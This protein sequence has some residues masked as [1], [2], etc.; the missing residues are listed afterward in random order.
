MGRIQK[1][2]CHCRDKIQ[3]AKVQLAMKMARTVREIKKS[4]L[5]YINGKKQIRNNTGPFQDEDALLTNRDMDMAEV[6]NVSLPVFSTDDRPRG[7]QCPE[8][9]NCECPTPS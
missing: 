9:E 6:F 7:S 4:F 2:C 5:T 8:L 3:M 1:C